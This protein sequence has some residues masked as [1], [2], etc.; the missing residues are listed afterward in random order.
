[1]K[2]IEKDLHGLF[3]ISLWLKAAH[4]VLEI[5]GG[6]ALILISNATIVHLADLLTRGELIEDP[7]DRLAS[8]IM[9]GAYGFSAG[10]KS[11]SA[12]YL[13]SHGVVKLFLIIAVLRNQPWAYPAFIGTLAALN[14]YQTYRLTHE[15]SYLLIAIT[16]LDLVVLVLAWHEYKFL[17]SSKSPMAPSVRG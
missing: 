7:H 6:L 13:L 11:F 3:Q 9:H 8:L 1:M 15:L 17:R 4:S 2:P 10:A 5:A 12:F 14:V 16:V